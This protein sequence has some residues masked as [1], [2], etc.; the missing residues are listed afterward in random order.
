MPALR[1]LFGKFLQN[2][3]S[4]E[5]GTSTYRAETWAQK[6][7]RGIGVSR[8][9]LFYGLEG[10]E[11]NLVRQGGVV[12]TRSFMIESERASGMPLRTGVVPENFELSHHHDV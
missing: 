11:N 3:T 9:K 4:R 1:Q 7:S 8:N 6:L 5:R 2:S 12:Q 10:D